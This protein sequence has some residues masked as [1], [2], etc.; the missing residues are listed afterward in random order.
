MRTLVLVAQQQQ[1]IEK[2]VAERLAAQRVRRSLP[3]V[4]TSLR[5]ACSVS[6]YSQMTGES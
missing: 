3:A 5:P 6:R 2:A 1:E 4:G